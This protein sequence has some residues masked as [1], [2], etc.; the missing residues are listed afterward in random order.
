MLDSSLLQPRDDLEDDGLDGGRD[1]GISWGRLLFVSLDDLDDESLEVLC[2][3]LLLLCLFLLS[4]LSS[5][6]SED[7]SSLS[8][9]DAS[10]VHL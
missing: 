1:D 7:S 9:S 6:S 5:L 8:S 3:P 4:D 10:L 2:P